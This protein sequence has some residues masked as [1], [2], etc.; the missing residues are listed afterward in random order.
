MRVPYAWGIEV[1]ILTIRVPV[2]AGEH[3][4][5]IAIFSDDPSAA[6]KVLPLRFR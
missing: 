1:K 4:A 2:A 6:M 3:V 5:E